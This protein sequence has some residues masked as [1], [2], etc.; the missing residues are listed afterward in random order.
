VQHRHDISIDSIHPLSR[1]EY[2]KMV[3]LGLFEDQKIEL[4]YGLLVD[5]PPI[6]TPHS[7]AVTQL[8]RLLLL[9]LDPRAAVRTQQPFAASDNSEPEPDVAIVP[10][11]SYT[12]AHPDRAHLI[13]EVSETSLDRDRTLKGR[14][15][16]E[17]GVPEYW[18]VNL[19][20]RVVEV[21][22][23][24]KGG[25]YARVDTR[26]PGERTALVEFPEVSIAVDEIFG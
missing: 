1:V 24:I 12:D 19:I 8:T 4:L 13:I 2:D 20:D 11:G 26:G 21:H 16:A 9:A 25:A 6:G 7:S 18:V 5:M 23:E 10:P 15:Y 14:L 3:E 17:C 22:T